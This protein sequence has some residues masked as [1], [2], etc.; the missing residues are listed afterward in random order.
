MEVILKEDVDSL[1]HRGDVVKVRA[2][3]GRNYLLP[4]GL[5]AEITAG[6]LQQLAHEKRVIESR[7]RKERGAAEAQRGKLEDLMLSFPRKVGEGDTL[8][9][10]VT[11]GDIA[12]ALASS[13]FHVDKRKIQLDEP[14]KALGSYQVQVKLHRDVAAT[15]RLVVVR[16][17]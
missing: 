2:G 15:I 8:Y 6:N 12:E 17:A 13:G 11:N 1:G 7:Q 4:R 3:Y 14:I 10:S 16:E 9:G 5:A